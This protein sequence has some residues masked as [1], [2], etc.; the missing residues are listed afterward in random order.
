MTG[1]Q[2]SVWYAWAMENESS[3]M[4]PVYRRTSDGYVRQERDRLLRELA[5]M[6]TKHK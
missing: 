6:E 1:A 5:A 3:M 2:A 4:G